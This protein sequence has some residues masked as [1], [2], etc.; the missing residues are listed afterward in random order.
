MTLTVA[1]LVLAAGAGR[2]F[3]Q[4][5]AVVELAGERLVD[6]AVRV[7]REGGCDAVYVVAGAIALDVPGATVVDN[8][9]W[10]T[11]MASSLRAGL[12]A[13]PPGVDAV[14]ISLVDQPG[15]GPEV[16]RRLIT[17]ASDGAQ[18]A[19]AAYDGLRRNPVLLT[20]RWWTDAAELATRDIGARAFLDARPDLVSIVESAD[21]GD[22]R[23]VDRPDDLAR[24]RPAGRGD[25]RMR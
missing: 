4:P 21:V 7:L 13:L 19:V 14:V 20:A 6:R 9:Q 23:D 10:E 25:H 8:P 2:R 1:G 22:P 17:A 11:G 16:V 5:K 18:V 3:G 15:I 24:V 12:A